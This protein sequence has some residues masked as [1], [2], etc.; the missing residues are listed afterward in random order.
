LSTENE[1][2]PPKIIIVKGKHSKEHY[3]VYKIEEFYK[4][5]KYIML[6]RD[7]LGYYYYERSERAKFSMTVDEI[8]SIKDEEIKNF[9]LSKYR[10]YKKLL[11]IDMKETEEEKLYKLAKKDKTGKYAA[12]LLMYRSDYEYERIEI[13][14]PDSF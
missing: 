10:D 2:W 4:L 12:D 14:Q 5:C 3:V 8:N 1:L 6:Y 7:E 11:L 9:A 13:I